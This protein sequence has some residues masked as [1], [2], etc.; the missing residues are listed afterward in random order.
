[1]TQK[2]S[3]GNLVLEHF[4]T[5]QVCGPVEFICII[6]AKNTNVVRSFIILIRV[7][8]LAIKTNFNRKVKVIY[9]DPILSFLDFLT[10]K[11]NVLRLVQSND[12]FLYDGNPKANRISQFIIK[13]Y[14]YLILRFCHSTKFCFSHAISDYLSKMNIKYH[15]LA[16]PIIV[17]DFIKQKTDTSIITS[18]M[19]NPQLKNFELLE[20]IARDFQNYTF[21]II[22]PIINVKSKLTNIKVISLDDREKL[23]SFL[24]KSLAHLSVS[25]KE[26]LG[27]PIFEA[28]AVNIPSIFMVNEG[29]K[30]ACAYSQLFFERYDPRM[31]SGLLSL[32]A[33]EKRLEILAKQKIFLEK[34]FDTIS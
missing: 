7:I 26:S 6:P 30:F 1:M 31:F 18:I 25:K 3:G 10:P 34:H 17:P 14:I 9:T 5:T 4:C 21:V 27:L 24:S 28:M 12:H 23:F 2:A 29:N 22:T 8:L 16:A 32:A 20:I 11:K 33:G 13:T 19:S 15:K